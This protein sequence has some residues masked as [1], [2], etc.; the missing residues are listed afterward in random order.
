MSSHPEARQGG[1]GG[2]DGGS[3]G[4]VDGRSH[5]SHLS[6]SFQIESAVLALAL[7]IAS[8]QL[9]HLSPKRH[10]G[11]WVLGGEG[12]RSNFHAD[13]FMNIVE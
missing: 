6:A 9:M 1:A 5:I 4:I 11:N 3:K 13:V 2:G 10:I 12:G 7:C 8:L